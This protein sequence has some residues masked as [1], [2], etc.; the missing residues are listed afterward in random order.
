MWIQI[1]NKLPQLR[2]I[3]LGM[4]AGCSAVGSIMLL[5]LLV[6]FLY[7]VAGIVF[8]SENDPAHFGNV[9]SAMLA[10]FQVLL[11]RASKRDRH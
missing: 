8:F 10:L 4:L 11:S 6:I 9:P 2:V 7:A 3:L 1:M 5:M